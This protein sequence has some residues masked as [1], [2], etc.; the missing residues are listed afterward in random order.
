[1][2][3]YYD[4]DGVLIPLT[5]E[6]LARIKEERILNSQK[7][8]EEFF[9]E[10]K[11]QQEKKKA[12][13]T[14]KILKRRKIKE[15]KIN[16]I[17]EMPNIQLDLTEEEISEEKLIALQNT[18]AKQKKKY[19]AMKNS[20]KEKSGDFFEKYKQK[21]NVPEV[22]TFFSEEDFMTEDEK[23]RKQE[24]KDQIE[25][26]TLIKIQKEKDDDPFKLK[27][28]YGLIV[29]SF[30]EGFM[31]IVNQTATTTNF[32][33][34][35]IKFQYN[36]SNPAFVNQVIKYNKDKSFDAKFSSQ[37]PI[38]PLI[39]PPQGIQYVKQSQYITYD[40]ETGI[41]FQAP[42]V[43]YDLPELY[44]RDYNNILK[45]KRAKANKKQANVIT[46][47]ELGEMDSA[48]IPTPVIQKINA[49]MDEYIT[50]EE[51]WYNVNQALSEM[52]TMPS[53]LPYLNIIEDPFWGDLVKN[54]SFKKAN[55]KDRFFS[56]WI[57]DVSFGMWIKI[58]DYPKYNKKIIL[59]NNV[60]EA[61]R[62]QEKKLEEQYEQLKKWDESELII[63]E[64]D[65]SKNNSLIK[66]KNNTKQDIRISLPFSQLFSITSI[67]KCVDSEVEFAEKY[68]YSI[69][70]CTN[71]QFFRSV[72]NRKAYNYFFK[73]LPDH[74]KNDVDIFILEEQTISPFFNAFFNKHVSYDDSVDYAVANLLQYV[75][76]HF[77]IY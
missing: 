7:R 60:S 48:D 39:T 61:I 32:Q 4:E 9:A 34:T 16:K 54:E 55:H 26:E 3:K 68:G 27:S 14:A 33:G 22:D 40:K 45:F 75:D 23:K 38:L 24:E 37:V 69:I 46:L 76:R 15:E 20:N 11:L 31:P 1:M 53:Y 77:K 35:N 66:G 52:I 19:E 56:K 43:K 28:I 50:R 64:V 73:D 72:T 59:S 42:D 30:E 47:D 41:P 71:R 74:L 62:N 17:V 44:K 70:C 2:A 67:S 51:Y 29:D 65:T 49:A 5:Q 57:R 18:Y 13:R 25:K 12:K 21:F 8:K 6:D 36:K 10:K 58:L 63:K